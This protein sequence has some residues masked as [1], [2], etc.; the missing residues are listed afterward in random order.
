MVFTFDMALM[1]TA[2]LEEDLLGQ[3]AVIG[4]AYVAPVSMGETVVATGSGV[5]NDGQPETAA[6]WKEQ[7]LIILA[8][9]HR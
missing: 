5:S 3:L 2:P 4:R 8:H 9:H 7:N 6:L 1:E